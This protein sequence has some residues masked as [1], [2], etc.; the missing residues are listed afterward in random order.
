[1]VPGHLQMVWRWFLNKDFKFYALDEA[2]LEPD[3]MKS[4]GQGWA[5]Q[6]KEAQIVHEQFGLKTKYWKKTHKNHP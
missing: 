3:S 5:I 1:M 6:D 4:W 2:S